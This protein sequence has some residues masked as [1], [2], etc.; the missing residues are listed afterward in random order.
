MPR[1][2]IHV[3]RNHKI[4]V[5]DTITHFYLLGKTNSS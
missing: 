1:Q 4:A 5:A 3:Y 2:F